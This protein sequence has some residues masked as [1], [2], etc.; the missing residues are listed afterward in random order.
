MARSLIL[1][2]VASTSIG[3]PSLTWAQSDTIP[4]FNRTIVEL[5]DARMG[6]RIGTGQCWDFVA[7]VLEKA[8]AKWDHKL[9][10]GREVDPKR[11][12]VHLGDIIQFEGVEVLYVTATSKRRESF[13]HHTAIIHDVK[14]KGEYTLAHQNVGKG[15]FVQLSDIALANVT[16]GRYRIYRPER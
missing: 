9:R 2:L 10:F 14:A 4:A 3:L 8:G 1:A 5:A 15:K 6:K 16:K 11:E 12:P 13:G 7:E